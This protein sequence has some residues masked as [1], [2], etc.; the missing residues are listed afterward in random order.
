[1]KASQEAI[2]RCATRINSF[3]PSRIVKSELEHFGREGD[4]KINFDYPFVWESWCLT[5]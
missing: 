2:L 5:K 1:M 4:I 3:I